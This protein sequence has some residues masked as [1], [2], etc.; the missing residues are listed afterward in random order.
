MKLKR[1]YK[2]IESIEKFYAQNR[3]LILHFAH[4]FRIFKGVIRYVKLIN[5]T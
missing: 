2:Y 5:F 1:M 3:H 4:I